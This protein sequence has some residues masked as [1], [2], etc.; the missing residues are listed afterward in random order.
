MEYFHSSSA[1]TPQSL[2]EFQKSI[3]NYNVN[4][5]EYDTT[6]RKL[7]EITPPSSLNEDS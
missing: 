6:S 2:N 4:K 3:Y 5:E 1:Y 7:S